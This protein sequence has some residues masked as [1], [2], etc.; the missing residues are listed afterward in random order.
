MASA[1]EG[2]LN[3]CTEI[4]IT[5]VVEKMMNQE[6]TAKIGLKG[7]HNPK[8]RAYRKGYVRFGHAS[9]IFHVFLGLFYFQAP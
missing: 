6:L 7:R 9:A 2:L 8:R 5:V 3:L 4:G 1:E